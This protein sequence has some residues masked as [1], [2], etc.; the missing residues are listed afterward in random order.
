ME[1]ERLIKDI[2]G[3]PGSYC[4]KQ[5]QLCDLIESR[6]RDPGIEYQEAEPRR[7][8]RFLESLTQYQ[9]EFAGQ[10]FK[11]LPWQ[12]F[13]TY[14]MFG[15]RDKET[16]SYLHTTVYLQ[17]GKKNGK[18]FYASGLLLYMLINSKGSQ[19]YTVATDYQQSQIAFEAVKQFI[20]NNPILRKLH[21][22]RELIINEAK[23][24][25][26]FKPYV[27]KLRCI[28][29]SRV[30]NIQGYLPLFVL[31]DECASYRNNDV[32]TKLDS[33]KPLGGIS[34]AITTAEKNTTNPA[35]NF[36]QR[37]E[38]VLSGKYQAPSFLPVIF[39]LD[40]EEWTRWTDESLYRK[41]NPSLDL[42]TTTLRKLVEERDTALQD[43]TYE[44]AF[45][46]Y[47][48]NIWLRNSIQGIADEDW[49]VSIA[50]YVKYK[51]YIE[52]KKLR[53]YPCYGAVDL[54]KIDDYTA[55]TLTFW[56]P[57]IEKFYNRHICYI[58]ATVVERKKQ[59]EKNN[60]IDQW[61]SD[62]ILVPT[63]GGGPNNKVV[64][65]DYVHE[66]IEEDIGKYE[67]LGVAVDD[68]FMSSQFKIALDLRVPR[69]NIVG[70][71]QNYKY[72]CP[73]NRL[74]LDVVYAGQLIDANPMMSWMVSCA[75]IVY[76]SHNNIYFEKI[77]YQQSPN[78]I[79]LVDTSVMATSRLQAEL[80][81]RLTS[82]KVN[83]K[84][85]LNF[86]NLTI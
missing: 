25:I 1:I 12:R 43:K 63:Q 34:L 37:S 31:Y 24:S 36:Y 17:I 26:I 59:I 40:P 41:A 54:S 29:E 4:K 85:L 67:L 70:F 60:S 3:A 69:L 78:R 82:G 8:I 52:G 11:L 64:N 13:L 76:G 27:N 22:N 46:A 14:A 79:D 50:N 23:L 39:E 55:Y 15:F 38:S 49:D 44:P 5:L 57:E 83:K 32:I 86:F 21:A 53:K 30:K 18:T 20:L 61:I 6:L 65:Y 7:V 58:P 80:D 81:I 45:K 56:I 73:A 9:G 16:G 72:L 71:A 66:Q 10:R 51:S 35:F 33:A 84:A 47:K 62:G 28:T 19:I 2:R 48:L 77:D 74:F 68:S 42:T 75:R